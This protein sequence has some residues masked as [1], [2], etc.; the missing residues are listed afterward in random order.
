LSTVRVYK[1]AE[2]LDMSSNDV[3]ALL[4]KNHGR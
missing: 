3:L 2:L 4:K 1:V